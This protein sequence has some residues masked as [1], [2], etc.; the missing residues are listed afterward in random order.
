M[1]L[2][3]QYNNYKRNKLSGDENQLIS[4]SQE[5][6]FLQVNQTITVGKLENLRRIIDI[7]YEF[8]KV[9]VISCNGTIVME[10][11]LEGI[12]SI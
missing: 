12:P 9:K 8:Y 7:K 5:Y 11:P 3:Q 6:T 10:K 2:T 1:Y 4:V